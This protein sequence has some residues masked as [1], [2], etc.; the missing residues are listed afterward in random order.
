MVIN[1]PRETSM[2]NLLKCPSC[3]SEDTKLAYPSIKDFSVSK[4]DFQVSKCQNCELLYTNPRPDQKG[5]IPYYDNVNYVSHSNTSKGLVFKLYHIVRNYALKQKLKLIKKYISKPTIL[6]Y[7]AGTGAFVKYALDQGAN[8]TGFE[9]SENARAVGQNDHQVTYTD[10]IPNH[11]TYNVITMWHVLEHIHN[12]HATFQN[13]VNSLEKDGYLFIAVPNHESYDAQFYKEYWA[14]WDIP[15][16]L[17][18]FNKTSFTHFTKAYNLK[19]EEIIPM[20]FD[21][22][23]VSL[24]SSK[25]KYGKTRYLQAFITGLMSNLKAG[26]DNYSSLIYVLRK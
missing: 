10:N 17:Y 23:Y 16:H 5:I 24:L 1:V 6:D 8:A 7:G 26:S 21:S 25:Y 22:F 12:L 2:E 13:L 11:P 19:L 9:I 3:A 4:E 14:A 15:I 20:K 18:H